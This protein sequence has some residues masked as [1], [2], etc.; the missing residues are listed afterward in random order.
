M[1]LGS[2]PEVARKFTPAAR[3]RNT[4][5]VKSVSVGATARSYTIL[6]PTDSAAARVPCH[7]KVPPAEFE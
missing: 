1:L 7:E 5:E 6:Y 2:S 3:I 4:S